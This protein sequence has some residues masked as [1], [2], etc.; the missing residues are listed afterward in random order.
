MSKLKELTWENHQNAERTAFA[1]KLMNGITPEQYH[2]YLY[3]Q[4][5]IYGSLE[6]LADLEDI[7]DI[8]RA[9]RISIDLKELEYEYGFKR[10]KDK[11][12]PSAVDYI[13]Y[14]PTLDN[15]ELMAHVYVRH[16]GD[17]Y[18]GQMIKK[19]IPF[20]KGAMYDFDNVEDL[21]T[22]VRT[23]LDDEMAEEANICFKYAT[24]LFEEL[25]NE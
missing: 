15:D 3:N 9:K 14:L 25:N 6:S 7:E 16:F 19:R 21:K 12:K 22:K 24:K 18:G 5:I 4:F 10:T 17:M 8:R 11:L 13:N 20:T 2:T 1:R 23:M